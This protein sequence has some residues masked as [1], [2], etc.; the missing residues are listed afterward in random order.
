MSKKNTL[1]QGVV[2]ST[3]P[4]YQYRYNAPTEPD[5]LPPAAQP[6]RLRFEKRNGKPTTVVEGF[7][8]KADDLEALC[9]RLK[10][11]CGTGG[12]AKE[13]VIL[14]QGD[15]REKLLGVLQKDGYGKV[16]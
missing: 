10:T 6:L 5:T 4:E 11:V 1:A 15:V 16:K 7:V 2:F 8:G 13:G 12:T 9:K 14:I 3:D